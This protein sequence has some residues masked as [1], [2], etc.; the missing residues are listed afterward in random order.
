MI[1]GFSEETQ[2]LTEYERKVILPIILEGLKTK[3]GKAN[4]VTNKYIISRLRDSYKIDAARLRKIINHIRTNDLLPGLI[5]TSEGYFLAT[6]E[7]ELLEYFPILLTAVIRAHIIEISIGDF[8]FILPAVAGFYHFL[9]T[10]SIHTVGS[11]EYP[12]C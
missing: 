1:K 7:S 9:N 11:S 5:A 8:R 3:I 2:P 12:E 10:G 4:A 6:T